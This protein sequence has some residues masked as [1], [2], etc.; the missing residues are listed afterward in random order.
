MSLEA[1]FAHLLP[2]DEEV[3]FFQEHGW[4]KSRKVFTDEQIE[5]ARRAQDEFY[6]GE[7][8]YPAV[9]SQRSPGWQP[10]HGDVLRKND[11]ASFRKQGLIDIVR[12]PI[13]GAIAAKLSGSPS[14]RLW[15]D[16]LLY[17]PVEKGDVVARVG[18]HTDYGYWKTCSS[19]KML[20]AWVP[21]HDCDAGMG[22]I[23]MI[24]GSHRWPDNTAHLDFFSNDLEGLEKRFVTG[25]QEIVKVPVELKAGE[26]S[27]HHCLTIHG[28]GP[29]LSDHPRRS[30]AVHLQDD[31]NRWQRYVHPDGNLATHDNDALVR[32][33]DGHPD[34]TDP[35]ICPQLWP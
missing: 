14:I 7:F 9:R 8:D 18:W 32:Q 12:S 27:F 11:H 20:T 4:Y 30:I 23:S 10:E 1:E 22:T 16:Q 3:R 29:N 19:P 26:I 15:H 13:V 21:F 25:G 5:A 28:S 6:A 24:D 2:S 31:A 33:V 34:Y 35:D 17:K